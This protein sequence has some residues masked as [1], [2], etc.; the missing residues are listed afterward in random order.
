[1]DYLWWLGC[2]ER[3]GEQ[4]SVVQGTSANF[5]NGYADGFGSFAI[6]G[7]LLGSY[8]EI[9]EATGFHVVFTRGKLI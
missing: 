6:L 3:L 5:G 1:L 9:E 8:L 7:F 2:L 4:D